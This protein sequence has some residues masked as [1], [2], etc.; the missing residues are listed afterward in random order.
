MLVGGKYLLMELVMYDKVFLSLDYVSNVL[1]SLR[2]GTGRGY[3][4]ATDPFL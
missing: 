4:Q 3:T 2:G 1:V